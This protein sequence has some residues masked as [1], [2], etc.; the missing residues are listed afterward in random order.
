[1]RT[2]L[3]FYLICL[4]MSMALTGQNLKEHQW[5]NRVVL[6]ITN[7]SESQNYASQLEEFNMHI[8]EFEERKLIYYKVLPNKYKL[9]SNTD[10]SWIKDSKLYAKYNPTHKNFSIVLIG[11]D[12]NV[13]T[14]QSNLLTITALFS[15]IDAMPM[16]RNAIRDNR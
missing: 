10:N 12:G 6:I 9:E 11:L 15:I 8:Q 4:T 13:K 16:R 7:D 14:E 2:Q 3:F 1:M 5:K